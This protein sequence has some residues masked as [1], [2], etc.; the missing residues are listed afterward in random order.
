MTLGDFE[1]RIYSRFKE[2]KIKKEEF[3][4]SI[5]SIEHGLSKNEIIDLTNLINEYDDSKNDI[6]QDKHKFC[7]IVLATEIGYEYEGYYYWP[8]FDNIS[9]DL[10]LLK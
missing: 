2:L 8:I 5:F 7:W 1:K 4:N 3:K 10:F 6:F 9:I